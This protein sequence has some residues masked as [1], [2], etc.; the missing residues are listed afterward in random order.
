VFEEIGNE[1]NVIKIEREKQSQEIG[2]KNTK[3]FGK[4]FAENF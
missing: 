2:R 3:S 1:G 4:I